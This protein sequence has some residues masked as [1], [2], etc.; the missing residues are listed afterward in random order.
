[1]KKS[2]L[3]I[4]VMVIAFVGFLSD[5]SAQ[6]TT[7]TLIGT[8]K[9]TKGAL[10]GASVK[11][12][13]T[14]TGTVYGSTTNADGRFTIV[15]MRPGGPYTIELSYVG[16]QAEKVTDVYLKLGEPYALNSVLSDGGTQLQEVVVS[17]KKDALFTG[18]KTGA[19][20][21]ITKE[22]LQTL[23]TLSRSLQD[24]TRLTPQAN[25]NSFGGI[26][27]RFNGL[28]IDGAVN[29]D[30]FGLGSTGAPGGQ[31]NTQPISLDA[32][33]EIQVVL[34]PFDVTNGNA[35]GGGVNAVTRSGSNKVEGSA[36][37]FGRNENVTGKSIDGLNAKALPFHNNTFGVRVGA[38]IIKDKL[39]FFISAERQSVVQPTI[40][41]AGDLNAITQSEIDRITKV[42]KDRYG[43]DVGSSNAYDTETQN[44]KIFARIDWNINPKNQLTIRHNYI[45]AYDDKLTR[46]ASAFAFSSN[47]YRFNDVQNNSVLEW[48]SAISNS[49]SNN[50]I[51][52]YSRIRDARAAEGALFPQIRING[53]AS[54]NGSATFGSESASTANELDQDIFEF[55]D[56]FKIIAN[57]HTFTFGTHNEFFKVR[58]LFINNMAGAYTWNSL[59]DFENNTKPAAAASIS[60][61]P[62][63]TRPAAKFSAAQLGFYFQDEIDAFTGFKLI[64]GLRVDVPQIFDKPLYNPLVTATFPEYRTDNVP[65]GQ[66][67]VSPRIS[68]N[69]DLTGDRSIQLRGGTG[70]LTSRAPFVWISNQFSNNGMLTKSVNATV[71]NGTFIADPN[72]QSA[73]GGVAGTTYEVNL[74]SKDFKLPQVFRSNIAVDVKLPLGIQATLE[75]LYSKTVNNIA[76]RNINMKPSVANINSALSGG[77]DTRPLYTNG[78]AAGK[79][80]G[81]F[82]NV[83]LLENTSA[84]SAYNLTAQLQK[85]FDMGLYLS[86]AYTYG[87]SEDVN[88]GFSST[89]SSGFGG[90]HI[91]QNPNVPVLAFSNYDLRHRV[92]GSLNYGIKYGKNKA[93][94]TTF[95]LF[96]VG[97]S[98]TPFSYIY[99]GDLNQDNTFSSGNPGNDLIYIPRSA[100]EIKLVTIPAVAATA[101]A[102]A[103]PE[104]TPAQQWAALDSYI[105]NDAYL[106]GRR[107]QYAERNGARMPWEHQ[108]DARIMQDLGLVFKGSKN[109]IQLTLDFINLGNLLNKEWGR[110][111]SINNTTYSL[112]NYSTSSGGGFTFR[113]PSGGK[114]YIESAFASRWQAQFGI[115]Y[116]FN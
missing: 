101:T 1:M 57:N 100:S 15:N 5:A 104:V 107:G 29:N 79:V 52:G 81:T 17:G 53:L 110:Q 108:F 32:I 26:N 47:L 55:T 62:G 21:N 96:Y 25:G 24:F 30:A 72:N 113:T 64:A 88:S 3:S 10:P 97:K 51:V 87:K 103:I 48:R 8:I 68:F 69:W 11:A 9:D 13:H 39:F 115:R 94:G 16:Y 70:L 77:A 33:Q 19:S 7:S 111:Y 56:N 14:P 31:A 76:Y 35:I 20:T 92:I 37:F 98:G 116:N 66:I 85:S 2:L 86:G 73:A 45:K 28:T 84:G 34:A 36:Y 38:P 63:D 40:N 46:A 74:I 67:L 12:T 22:Q 95:S 42:A 61:V 102:A 105:T 71:G 106:S 112:I 80:N 18:K 91:V 54:I 114:P 50:L 43:Y 65:S 93:S 89:A 109:S 83:F 60:I 23:P 90:P 41:N 58:N 59:A 82:T 44:D 78:N 99:N 4:V 6:V 27:N 75:A 49:L